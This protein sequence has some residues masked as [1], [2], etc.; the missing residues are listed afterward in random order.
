M[1]VIVETSDLLHTVIAAL[2]AGI[3]ITAAF[4]LAIWGAARFAELSRGDR[5]LAAGG[6]A[7]VGVVALMVTLGAIVVGIVVMMSK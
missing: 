7:V 5:P 6:A 4:S 2:V 1:A 3:G